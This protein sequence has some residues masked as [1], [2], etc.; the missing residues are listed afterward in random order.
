MSRARSH[1]SSNSGFSGGSW[2]V[3]GAALTALLEALQVLDPIVH[4]GQVLPDSLLTF[5]S[6]RSGMT[7]HVMSCAELL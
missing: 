2:L 6:F 4:Q 1:N 5:D 7:A 3:T